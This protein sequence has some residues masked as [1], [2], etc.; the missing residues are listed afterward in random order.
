MLKFSSSARSRSNGPN[1][2]FK[3]I[4]VVEEDDVD[5]EVTDVD[6][7]AT[8]VEEDDEL[9]SLFSMNLQA[10]FSP[11]YSSVHVK[12]GN[13]SYSRT[14]IYNRTHLHLIQ[15]F[16][17]AYSDSPG[18][19]LSLASI[20]MRGS[21]HGRRVQSA[22]FRGSFGYSGSTCNEPVC[23]LVCTARPQPPQKK[24]V[25]ASVRAR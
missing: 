20:M 8:D 14:I 23:S 6:E 16:K 18:E 21:N 4:A 10:S 24:A 1:C 2:R 3:F 22:T 13:L 17:R 11:L 19:F 25:N 7:E 5:E 12:L 9:I 15:S